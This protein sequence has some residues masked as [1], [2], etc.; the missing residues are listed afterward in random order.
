[1]CLRHTSK[2]RC[3]S[4][5]LAGEEHRTKSKTVT[6]H[7]ASCS[8]TY[9]GIAV[10]LEWDDS[11]IRALVYRCLRNGNRA[12]DWLDSLLSITRKKAYT[13]LVFRILKYKEAK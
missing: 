4:S 9:V 10:R 13:S 11:R 3:R 6:L 5:P 8:W 12:Y 7:Q 1:M 2:H